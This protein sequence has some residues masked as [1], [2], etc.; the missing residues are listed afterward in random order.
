MKYL[1][2]MLSI[3]FVSGCK[4]NTFEENFVSRSSADV[5]V[6]SYAALNSEKPQI[7]ETEEIYADV[8]T[9]M[10]QDYVMLGFNGFDDTMKSM[11]LVEDFAQ[12][13]GA[14]DVLYSRTYLGKRYKNPEYAAQPEPYRGSINAKLPAGVTNYK[15]YEK[16]N[17]Y[18]YSVYYLVKNR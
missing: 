15:K 7:I 12:K 13:I 1:I 14:T 9:L 16:V 18:R 2:L 10:E 5:S 8:K 11:K 3:T 4:S 17:M 6:Q